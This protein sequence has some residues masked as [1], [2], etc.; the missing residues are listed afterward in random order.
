MT[1]LKEAL[2]SPSEAHGLR[3]LGFVLRLVSLLGGMK[4]RY[5]V[6]VR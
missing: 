3:H 5:L 2:L 4:D 1:L 6:F